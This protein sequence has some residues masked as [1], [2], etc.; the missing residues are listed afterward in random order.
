MWRMPFFV[1]ERTLFQ[2]PLRWHNKDALL[3]RLYKYAIL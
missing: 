3:G 1:P 2:T